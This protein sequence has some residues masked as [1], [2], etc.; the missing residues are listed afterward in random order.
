[1]AALVG[2]LALP[3]TTTTAHASA[4]PSATDVAAPSDTDTTFRELELGDAKPEG[5]RDRTAVVDSGVRTVDEFTV[6]GISWAATETDVTARYRT[7][8]DGRWT[9]WRET[10]AGEGEQ[11]ETRTNSDALV[12]PPSTAV[13]VEVRTAAGP[14]NDVKVVLIDGG[15]GFAQESAAAAASR[16]AAQSAVA[17]SSMPRPAIISRAQWGA[18]ESMR[19]CSPDYTTTTS[20]AA[21]HHTVSSNT[22]SAEAAAGVVRGIYAYHTRAESSGG[23]G[24]CDIGYNAL[25]DRFGRVYEG[26][27]GSFDQSVVGVHTGGFNSRTF[28]VSVIGDHSTTVP[29][30]QVLEGVSQAIAW[31]FA[32]E[33]ILANTTVTMVSGGGASKYP[34]G[35]PVTFHTIYAHRDAAQTACPG[36]QLYARIQQVRDRVAALAN[37]VVHASPLAIWESTSTTAGSVRVAGWAF[38][39]E[40]TQSLVVDVV[41]DGVS[42]PVLA[43]DDRPDVAAAYPG[44]GA[45][46]GFRAEVPLAPGEHT[47]CPWVRN[48]GNGADQLLGCRRVTVTNTAP[49]GFL[50]RVT[51]TRSTIQVAGWALD[52]DVAGPVQVHVYAGPTFIGALTADRDRPD[53]AAAFPQAGGAHGFTGEIPV[54]AG[55]HRVCVYAINAPAGVNPS[56]G[57]A[58]VDV[59][60]ATP[61]GFLDAVGSDGSSVRVEG[62]AL[63]TDDATAPVQVH[64]YAGSTFVGAVTADQARQDIAAAYPGAGAAHGFAANLPIAAGRHRICVYAINAPAGVNPGLGCRQ[65]DVVNPEPVGF[66]DEVVRTSPQS[67]R[68][69]GWAVDTGA[70]AG[71]VQVH[72]YAGASFLGAVSADQA[73]PD[74]GAAYRWAGERHGFSF[75]VPLA[76]GPARVC[77]YAINVPA[78]VNP[79]VGC[80]DVA[81]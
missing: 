73:R 36:E 51:A 64:V 32:T 22:Y 69:S 74:V 63:D 79:S 30:A 20:A 11:G 28:G 25:V 31:K 33:R 43:G 38:D 49:V 67:V 24:W 19:T 15:E 57:C 18:D 65:V 45:A 48:V 39:P 46:H 6:L 5:A 17:A 80:R 9:P 81:S 56:L 47:V 60:N 68:V 8:A 61:V 77:V 37:D 34:E 40:S 7:R 21:V 70:G 42:H 29:S 62:W 13:E 52:A 41:V 10:G 16:S 55:R 50:D 1:M 75:E 66:V 54:A 59:V 2:A 58:Q 26:R 3:L 78:G 23:R 76:A 71:P 4:S 35:T 53:I 27:A 44:A 14:V 12:V 72:V